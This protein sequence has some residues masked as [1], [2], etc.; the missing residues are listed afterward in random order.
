MVPL[1]RQRPLHRSS[2]VTVEDEFERASSPGAE[3]EKTPY[4]VRLSLE[5]P[6]E[7]ETYITFV[8]TENAG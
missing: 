3:M 8:T 6:M 2:L 1:H 5:M 7:M 4:V